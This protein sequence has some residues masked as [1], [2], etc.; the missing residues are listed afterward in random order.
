MPHSMQDP[1][2]STR[3]WTPTPGSKRLE[4]Q[5][6][7]KCDISQYDNVFWSLDLSLNGPWFFP[8]IKSNIKIV[9]ILR[10]LQGICHESFRSQRKNTKNILRDGTK[11]E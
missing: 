4:S 11:L 10:I 7:D 8:K 5:P 3:D 1:R 6:L 9:T 2:S